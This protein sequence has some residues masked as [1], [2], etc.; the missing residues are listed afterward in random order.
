MG[1]IFLIIACFAGISKVIAMKSSGKVCSGEYNSIR[2]NTFRS[3]ICGCVSVVTFLIAGSRWNGDYWWIWLLSG[4]S[5]AIMM[6]VW[7]LSTQRVG[8]IFIEAFC[9]IGSTAI[10]MIVAPFLYNGDTVSVWQWIGMACLF[11]AVVLLSVKPKTDTSKDLTI[12]DNAEKKNSDK[13]NSFLTWLYI[14]LLVVSNAGVSITQKLYPD[15][16][17]KDYTAFFNLMTFAVVL[18]C[19]S[20]ILVCG[21]I[22]AKKSFLPEKT[23]SAKKLVIFVTI[24]AV[25]IYIYQY[26]STTAAALLPSAVFYPLTRGISMCLTVASDVIIFKQKITK[27]VCIGLF[28]IFAA[29]ILTNL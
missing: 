24:A 6:F 2:I 3:I 4:L 26:F 22:I 14:F 9:L 21:K 27:N 18:A 13:K 25:M 8:L 20:I 15:K 16:V 1:Y 10:P 29:I 19:F 7:I 5:N 28:F 17:G 12:E 11:I 23:E